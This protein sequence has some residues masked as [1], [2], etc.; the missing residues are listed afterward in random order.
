MVG[1]GHIRSCTNS[2]AAHRI[3]SRSKATTSMVL[4]VAPRRSPATPCCTPSTTTGRTTPVT[5]S[6]SPPAPRSWLRV[7]SSPA[8]RRRSRTL[9]PAVAYSPSTTAPQLLPVRSSSAVLALSTRLPTRA[10]SPVPPTRASCPTSVASRLLRPTR[11][12]LRLSR[13]LLVLVSS[14]RWTL[15]RELRDLVA[16]VQ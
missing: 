11:L 6:R 7:M 14:E 8:S 5:P 13:L 15:R 16:P 4:P 9:P 3:R 10:I 2:I 12:R 1:I